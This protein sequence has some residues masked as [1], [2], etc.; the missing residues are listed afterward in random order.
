M[1]TNH[2]HAPSRSGIDPSLLIGLPSIDQ[3]HSALLAQ[4]NRLL[5]NHPGETTSESFSDV[6]SRLGPQI[7]AHFDS[8]ERILKTSGMPADQVADHVH[9]HTVILEQYTQMNCDLMEGKALAWPDALRMVK[10]WIIDHLQQ[11]DAKL[12]DYV[13]TSR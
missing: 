5:E 6:L 8:E 2:H 12:E 10:G 1:T 11:F 4:F 3:E 9:A 7:S 13:Q